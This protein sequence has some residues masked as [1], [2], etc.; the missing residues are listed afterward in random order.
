MKTLVRFRY[1]VGG[2]LVVI[3]LIS[4]VTY[5]QQRAAEEYK[6]HH[7]EYCSALTA[8]AEQKKACIEKRAGAQDYLPWGYELFRWPDG[9]TAWAIIVTGFFIGWQ[10]RETRK[11]AEATRE[12]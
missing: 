8:T 3:A 9:I 4:F 10:A 7:E 5:K 2:V 12:R 6:S 11:A 1:W